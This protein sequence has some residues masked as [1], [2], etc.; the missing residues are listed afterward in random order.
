MVLSSP[1]SFAWC[2]ATC[3]FRRS[4]CLNNLSQC[5][6]FVSL[7]LS[8]LGQGRH[9]SFLGCLLIVYCCLLYV[10]GPHRVATQG[11]ISAG[12]RMVGASSATMFRAAQVWVDRAG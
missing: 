3:C 8:S 1:A 12:A 11:G 10:Q 5:G 6:H 2:F 4:S 7:D 9:H